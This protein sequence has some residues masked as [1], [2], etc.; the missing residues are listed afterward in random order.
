MKQFKFYLMAVAAMFALSFASCSDDDTPELEQEPEETVEKYFDIWVKAGT[1]EASFL[2]RNVS[3]VSD[4]NLVIDYK[5]TGAD[6]TAKLDEEIIFKDE[7]PKTLV[8]KVAY[9]TL[10]EEA[11]KELE[12]VTV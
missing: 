11:E 3:D 1:D 10:E 8:G 7:L 6:I 2:V 5:N 4:P 12:A 9:H